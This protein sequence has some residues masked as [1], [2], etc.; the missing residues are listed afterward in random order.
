MKFLFT[1][2]LITLARSLRPSGTFPPAT[3]KLQYQCQPRRE[4]LFQPNLAVKWGIHAYLILLGLGFAMSMDPHEGLRA[5]AGTSHSASRKEAREAPAASRDRMF[6]PTFT[7]RQEHK[8]LKSKKRKRTPCIT[9]I[10]GIQM[11]TWNARGLRNEHHTCGLL[12]HIQAEWPHIDVLLL[13][14]TNLRS[15]DPNTTLANNETWAAHRVDEFP[16]QGRTRTGGLVLLVKRK[17]NFTVT[18]LQDFKQYFISAASWKIEHASW[19]TPLTVH[20]VYRNHAVTGELP[21]GTSLQRST[22]KLQMTA[23]QIIAASMT[24]DKTLS[25]LLGDFN[26]WIGEA[27]QPLTDPCVR[28]WR[29]RKSDHKPAQALD[30]VAKSF[31]EIVRSDELLVLNGR[32]GPSSASITYEKERKVRGKT[33]Y[34]QSLIDYALCH[35]RW[36][37]SIQKF[38]IHANTGRLS[39]HRPLHLN[40]SCDVAAEALRPVPDPVPD[41]GCWETEHRALVDASP[42]KLPTDDPVRMRI[43]MQYQ[44]SIATRLEA[45]AACLH[46]LARQQTC[47]QVLRHHRPRLGSGC[48]PSCPCRNMQASLDEV[49]SSISDAIIGAAEEVLEHRRPRLAGRRKSQTIWRPGPEWRRLKVEQTDAWKILCDTDPSSEEHEVA[50][51]NHKAACRHLRA[52]VTEDRARWQSAR[53]SKISLQGPGH[54]SKGAWAYLKRHVGGEEADGGLPKRVKGPEGGI[55]REEASTQAWHAARSKIGCY[56][57][58]HPAFDA[59]AHAARKLKLKDIETTES[60]RIREAKPPSEDGDKMMAAITRSELDAMLS[61]SSKGTSPGTDR[62]HYELLTNGGEELK[63]VL[64]LLYNLAW[65]AGKHPQEW[66]KA[67][68]RPLYKP[69]TKDPLTIENYRAVTL[70]NCICKGYESI[71]FNRVSAHLEGRKGVSPGQGAR[72][73]T[74]TEELLYAITSTARD[75]HAHSG[76]GTYA[77]FIDFTLAYPSTDHHVIFTKMHDKGI[78]GRLWANIRHLY[79]DMKSRVMHP[80]IP[81]EEFFDIHSGVREGSVLSPI[82]FI[83][84]VDDM[85]EYLAA[86]PYRGSDRWAGQQPHPKGASAAPHRRGTTRPPG[87]WLRK[88]YLALLQFVDDS[89]LLA[90]SPQELQHMID[91]IAEYCAMY[92]LSVNPRPGKTEVVEFMCEASGFEYTIATPTASD[93]RHR[94]SLR[95]SPGYRYLGSWIDKWLT[96]KRMVAE[97]MS[98]VSSETDKVA[99]MGGQPGGLPLRTTFQLWSALVLSHVHPIA[100]VS[101]RQVKKLQ[102]ALLESVSKL[103]GAAADPQAVLADLGLPDAF[104]LHDIRLGLLVNRLRT[105]PDY[106]TAAALHRTLMSTEQ[107][108]ARGVEAAYL[109]TLLRHRSAALWL[110]GPAP[111]ETLL[112]VVT[113]NGQLVDPIRQARTA[114]KTMWKKTVWTSRCRAMRAHC[115]PFESP[116]F[117]LFANIAARDLERRAPWIRASYLHYEVGPKHHLA[118]FQFRT[119]SSLLAAHQAGA[120]EESEAVDPRCDGCETRLRFLQKKHATMAAQHPPAAPIILQRLHKEIAALQSLLSNDPPE[121]WEHALFHCCKGSLPEHRSKWLKDMRRIFASAQ[122]RLGTRTG[123]VIKWSDLDMET[124][125]QVALGTV[126]PSLDNTLTGDANASWHF[127]GKTA[128]KRRQRQEEFHAQVVAT[129]SAFALTIC[130]A[131][132]NYKK[133]CTADITDNDTSWQRVHATW[134]WGPL[135][136]EVSGSDVDQDNNSDPSTDDE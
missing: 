55:L 122:P 6:D 21:D 17:R 123:P 129:C 98:S 117:K 106:M 84:A 15:V 5:V 25:V 35:Q 38:E 36:A 121:D 135:M 13:T 64:L 92:R 20:G 62:I 95:I 114:F 97:M 133:A 10:R 107:N 24:S 112:K 116:K 57:D 99:A 69:K 80:G 43:E 31:M 39:D 30:Y 91:V 102:W 78:R 79:R 110:P 103:A 56:D 128:K 101:D 51:A 125:V 2:A 87:V 61:E 46:A 9:T 104:T 19:K 74:G 63:V 70:I 45:P 85:L 44:S 18:K 108:R 37:P 11:M 42:F 81:Q 113:E 59:S 68:I 12:A 100:L 52:H 83:I 27:Q 76:E 33:Q 82:L 77:C 8:L 28:A 105:L 115:E 16:G 65:A 32:F 41:A 118:L 7:S 126:P 66:N 124:K 50:H 96:F 89:V 93:P 73:H 67:L 48:A 58:L 88:V 3:P 127:C 111:N 14:E 131:L 1:Q 47:C 23:L 4:W 86:R 60:R 26:L 40:I 130:Q 49:Y 71:L 132:R 72:R 53:F 22:E 136:E 134:D 29:L 54:T 90:A 94:T 34:S 119:Q 109:R 75:R 120:A